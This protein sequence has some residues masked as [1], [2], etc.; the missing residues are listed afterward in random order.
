[1]RV[2]RPVCSRFIGRGGNRMEEWAWAKTNIL[3]QVTVE[4]I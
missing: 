4:E 1:M 3:K 2:S